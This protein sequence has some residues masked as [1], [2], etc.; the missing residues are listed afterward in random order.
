MVS[1]AACVSLVALPWR[2]SL[3]LHAE[4]RHE[5]ELEGTNSGTCIARHCGRVYDRDST[6][7]ETRD[8]RR[9]RAGVFTNTSF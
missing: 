4:R 8:G 3:P 2:C 5:R 6:K 9:A 1:C 7:V